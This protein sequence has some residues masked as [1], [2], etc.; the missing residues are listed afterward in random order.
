MTTKVW[1]YYCEIEFDYNSKCPNCERDREGLTEEDRLKAP[2]RKQIVNPYLYD[3]MRDVK[4]R[5][6]KA[7]RAKKKW[8]NN[9]FS[10][11]IGR[12]K[13]I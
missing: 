8:N 10:G 1:C 11:K 3:M 12:V 9:P 6:R 13:K 5:K 4:K 7:E 2:K